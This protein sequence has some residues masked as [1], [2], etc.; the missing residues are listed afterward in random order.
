MK[1]N[2]NISLRIT[3]KARKFVDEMGELD[4][5]P[6]STIVNH[7]IEYFMQEESP[8]KAIKKLYKR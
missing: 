1:K 3:E 6:S 7:M 5:R 8:E 2:L 4:Q